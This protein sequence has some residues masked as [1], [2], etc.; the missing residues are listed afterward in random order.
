MNVLTNEDIEKAFNLFY[1]P[2]ES[3]HGI[4]KQILSNVYDSGYDILKEFI[5]ALDFNKMIEGNTTLHFNEIIISINR[6]TEYKNNATVY[7]ESC[8]ISMGMVFINS[9]NDMH[10]ARKLI[11]SA[12]KF[13]DYTLRERERLKKMYDEYSLRQLKIKTNEI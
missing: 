10:K 6:R 11:N 3:N 5:K 7:I 13:L 9:N 12:F 2:D 8:R 4:A 1:S